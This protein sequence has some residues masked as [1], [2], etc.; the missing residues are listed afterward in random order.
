MKHIRD[1][2]ADVVTKTKAY[3]LQKVEAACKGVV[4]ELR[5][6]P[7]VSEWHTYCLQLVKGLKTHNFDVKA[8]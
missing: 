6:V 3:F 5:T 1:E 8:V 4:A 2:L 7:E